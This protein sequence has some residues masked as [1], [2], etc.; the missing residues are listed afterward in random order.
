MIGLHKGAGPFGLSSIFDEFGI[1]RAGATAEQVRSTCSHCH[2]SHPALATPIPYSNCRIFPFDADGDGRAQ[3]DERDDLAAGGIGTD[4]M[5]GFEVDR[6]ELADK[7]VRMPI[8]R[9]PSTHRQGPVER[10]EIAGPWVRTPPLTTLVASAPYLHNGSVPTLEAL[11]APSDQRPPSFILGS[12][13]GSFHLRHPPTRQPQHRPRIRH[14]A[15]PRREERPDRVLEEPVMRLTRSEPAS[16]DFPRSRL[17]V[18]NARADGAASLARAA[19]V[20]RPRRDFVADAADQLD[21]AAGAEGGGAAVVVAHVAD[22]HV[23]QAIA[24]R[25][26]AC[27]LQRRKRRRWSVEQTEIGMKRRKVQRQSAP[28]FATSQR[29]ISS[30]SASPSFSPRG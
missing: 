23:A 14:Q 4:A 29:V 13:E 16:G 21:T 5:F 26:G 9:I 10:V 30:S 12:G 25:D 6:R 18:E 24:A 2:D 27:T 28:K 15:E 8:T 20:Q 1:D 7:N 19:R 11:L 3:G 22:V 17:P